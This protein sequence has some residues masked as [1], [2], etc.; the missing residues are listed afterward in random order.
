MYIELTNVSLEEAVMNKWVF[1]GIACITAA[2]AVTGCAGTK[3]YVDP[4]GPK[5]AAYIRTWPLGSTAEAMAEGRHWS[6]KDVKAGYLTDM[7][8]SFGHLKQENGVYTGDIYFPDIE[9]KKTPF[10]DVWKN[11]AAL[12]K[13]YPHLKVNVSFGGWGADG[14]SEVAANDVKRG[15]FVSHIT[16]FLKQYGLDGVDIDWEYPVGPDWGQEI[17]CQPADKENY[18]T[19]LRDIRSALNSLG[20]ET[21]K[22]YSLSVAVP[23]SSWY[24]QKIDVVAL[25]AIVDSMKLMSYDYYGAWSAQT[26]HNANLMNNPA[27]PDWGGWSTDQAV[28]MYLDAG[29]PPEKLVLGLAFY[30]RAWK[31]AADNGV[32]GL[33]QKYT[34][35]A[36]PDGLSWP[37]LQE[38]LKPESG[39]TR[40]WDDVAKAPF[41]YNGD[42]FISYT[43]E[44]QIAEIASYAAGKGLGGVMIW[45]YGHDVD[46]QL[47]KSLAESVSGK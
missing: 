3:A 41:L 25:A 9:N 26:G 6:A 7:I 37:D 46:A 19:L 12:K 15:R 2:V 28:R 45:E 27:D 36:Y 42:I 10:P 8:V 22:S 14:F 33:Y 34:E 23:A 17:S 20:K 47:L 13:T 44:Q 21:G 35:A 24:P 5:I 38:F 18:L 32:H 4:D 40:Y 11:V 39:Y 1:A 29:V 16:A 31:G 43:D 30:G